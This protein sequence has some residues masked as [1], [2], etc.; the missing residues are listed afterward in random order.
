MVTRGL[1][2][3]V[4]LLLVAAGRAEETKERR[5][6]PP[7]LKPALEARERIEA[8]GRSLDKLEAELVAAMDRMMPGTFSATQEKV[9][10]LALR[11]YVKK[12]RAMG[13]ELIGRGDEFVRSSKTYRDAVSSAPGAFREASKVFAQYADEEPFEDFKKEYRKMSVDW[14]NIAA[15]MDFRA[16]EMNEDEVKRDWPN[17]LRYLERSCLFLDRLDAFLEA[18]PVNLEDGVR[19]EQYLNDLKRYLDGFESLRKQLGTL[20]DKVQKTARSP[21]VRKRYAEEVA[22][23]ET[24]KTQGQTH[25]AATQPQAD[26][27]QVRKDTR[28]AREGRYRITYV[29][30]DLAVLEAGSVKGLQSGQALR[31]Y[32]SGSHVANVRVTSTVRSDCCVVRIH[33]G[34]VR[35][36]DY[37]DVEP[38][39]VART[40]LASRTGTGSWR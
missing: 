12:L 35:V 1:V 23:R 29:D 38:S 4:S 6:D 13:K 25:R 8:S 9:T 3:L 7:Q 15:T 21:E 20:R 31:L 24:M 30:Q 39:P 32:R 28:P 5:G 26:V 37:A 11:E 16:K 14:A 34:T 2:V 27:P 22:R 40:E 18:W 17:T 10:V 36:G 33:P 19:R